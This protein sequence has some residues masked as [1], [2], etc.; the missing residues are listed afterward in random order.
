MRFKQ[1]GV[2]GFLHRSVFGCLLQV[3]KFKEFDCIDRLFVFRCLNSFV[4]PS[5]LKR[6]RVILCFEV[7]KI[8]CFEVRVI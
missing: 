3:S 7:R 2:Y 6:V 8:L 4:I 5:L 1:L